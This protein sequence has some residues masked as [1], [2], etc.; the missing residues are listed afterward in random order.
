PASGD[1]PPRAAGGPAGLPRALA[2]PAPQRVA[3][4]CADAAGRGADGVA[5]LGV[6]LWVV[7]YCINSKI[8]NECLG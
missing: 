2:W 8:G 6:S 5:V 4:L 7:C 3:G 1:C